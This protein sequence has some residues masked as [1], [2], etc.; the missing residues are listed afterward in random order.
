MREAY[1]NPLISPSAII[2]QS[3]LCSQQ[4]AENFSTT[5]NHFHPLQMATL[6]FKPYTYKPT[7]PRSKSTVTHRKPAPEQ[8]SILNKLQHIKSSGA[9]TQHATTSSSGCSR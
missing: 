2:F 1:M 5:P 9:I 3:S 8:I 4:Q 7:P 6:A